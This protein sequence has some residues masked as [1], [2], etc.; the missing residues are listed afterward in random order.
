MSLKNDY[1][2]LVNTLDVT[3]IKDMLLKLL[4]EERNQQNQKKSV[5]NTI[6][7][8][9][10]YDNDATSKEDVIK[11]IETI[12]KPLKVKTIEETVVKSKS[13]PVQRGT[14]ILREKGKSSWLSSLHKLGYATLVSLLVSLQSGQYNKGMATSALAGMQNGIKLRSGNIS[15]LHRALGYKPSPKYC[16]LKNLRTV[17]GKKVCVINNDNHNWAQYTKRIVRDK[18]HSSF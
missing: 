10:E 6:I 7:I 18:H 2:K 1:K 4:L 11:S 3:E 8:Q 14:K 15:A 9:N 17:H 13:T 12:V 16:P 5:S